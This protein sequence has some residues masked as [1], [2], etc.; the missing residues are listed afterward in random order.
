MI[1][2]L[3]EKRDGKFPR[4]TQE[5]LS[6]AIRA[7]RGLNVPVAALVPG[8]AVEEADAEL[9]GSWGAEKILN[10]VNPAV[11]RYHPESHKQMLIE[12]I[13]T[14]K[15]ALIL[16]AGTTY[17]RELASVVSGSLGIAYANDCIELQIQ[18]GKVVATRPVYAG[19]ARAKIEARTSPFMATFRPNMCKV[20]EN[21]A[22]QKAAVD[23]ISVTI[24]EDKR[25]S[26]LGVQASGD[27]LANLADARIIVS[28]G[29]GLQGPENFPMLAELA[30]SMGA[31]LGASRMVVDAG[32][33]EH[34]HQVGQTGRTVTPDLYIACGISG[35]IQHLAGMSSA[36]CIVAINKDPEAPI[37]KVA[38]YG[39]VGDLFEIIPILTRE[40]R[41]VVGG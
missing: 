3:A 19:K 16:M 35:A 22:K 12:I 34:K 2:V 21:L 40:M 29:R 9:L 10:A 37:F 41:T 25:V 33:I 27:L 6:E 26:V 15:P 14:Q 8:K 24:S 36:K 13:R 20:E 11:E 18:N 7:K 28:G 5:L 32:W 38:D 39:I 17:G 1:L 23:K 30:K 31:A 4:V